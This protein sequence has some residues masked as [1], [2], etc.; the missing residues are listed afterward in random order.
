[1]AGR[2][3]AFPSP[4][5]VSGMGRAEHNVLCGIDLRIGHPLDAASCIGNGIF[6]S[7]SS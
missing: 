7:M 6:S 5:S 3:Q 1:M 4:A 2:E